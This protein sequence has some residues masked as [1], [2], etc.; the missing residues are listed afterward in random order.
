M[1]DLQAT[2]EPQFVQDLAQLCRCTVGKVNIETDRELNP[3]GEVSAGFEFGN[4][5]SP[6]AVP[7]LWRNSPD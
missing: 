2:F 1:L 7:D 4:H 3:N 5:F 6:Q